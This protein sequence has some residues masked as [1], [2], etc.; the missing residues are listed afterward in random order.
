[1]KKILS[2]KFLFWHVL[3]CL[4]LIGSLS[5][6]ESIFKNYSIAEGL[7]HK[8]V[9][10]MLH[11][12]EG[13]VWVG[14]TSG[15]SRFDSYDFRNFTHFS[16]NTHALKGTTIGIILEGKDNRIWFLTD[17]GLEYFDKESETFHLVEAHG[18]KGNVYKK[19]TIDSEGNIWMLHAGYQF[20]AYN[21]YADSVFKIIDMPFVEKED[22]FNFLVD[23]NTL[24]FASKKGI[25]SYNL[26]NQE[27]RWLERSDHLH[28]STVKKINESTVVFTFFFEGICVLNT[29]S[30]SITWIRKEFIE[31]EIGTQITLYD[32]EVENDSVFWISVA[33]GL[34]RVVNGSVEYFN[35]FSNT[36]YFEG[37][38]VSCLYRDK[39]DNI[40]V[41]TYENGI[42]LKQKKN[43]DYV[44]STRLHRD[45]VRKTHMSNFHVFENNSLLYGDSKGIYYCDDY[46]NLSAG[47]AKRILDASIPRLFPFDER[48]CMMSSVDTFYVFDSWTKTVKYSHTTVAPACVYKDK[49]NDII[50]VGTWVGLLCGYDSDRNLKFQL[51]VDTLSKTQFPIFAIA[52]DADGS[53]WL[54]TV[55]VG[56]VHIINP[57]G[58]NPTIKFYNQNGTGDNFLNTNMIHS[59]HFDKDFNLWVG[60]NGN[61]VVRRDGKTKKMT[62]YTTEDGLKSNVIESIVSDNDGNIWFA[63]KVVTRLDVTSGTFTHFLQAEGIEGS[64][65][66]NACAKSASGDLLFA[67]SSGIYIFDPDNLKEDYPALPPILTQL[68]IR[69]VPVSAGDTIEGVVPYKKSITFTDK[70]SLP[71]A[72]NTFSIAFASIR[73]QESQM[74]D[75]QFKLDGVDRDW[76]PSGS[77]DR[78]ASYIGIQPGT[79]MFH[80]RA[81]YDSGKWSDAKTIKIN[82]IPPWWKTIWFNILLVLFSVLIITGFVVYRFQAIKRLNLLLERKVRQRTD[83]LIEANSLLQESY[84]VLEVKNEALDEALKTK[85]KLI[86]IIAHDFKNPLAAII[87]MITLLKD[88]YQQLNID[89]IQSILVSLTNSSAN[90]QE[91]MNSVLDWA[92]SEKQDVV[93][94][95]I[96]I[97]I[98]TLIN[99]SIKLVEDI[100]SQKKISI[101]CQ[102][103]YITTAYV[104]PRMISAVIRNLLINAIKF[105]PENGNIA[106][107]VQEYENEI[108]VSVVDSGIG[109]SADAIQLIFN[110]QESVS[111]HDTD[112]NTSTGLG[113]QLS[114]M[115]VEKNGGVLSARSQQNRGSVFIFTVPK[116]GSV[117]VK[118]QAKK[119]E[120][121]D[122][123]RL[124]D[125]ANVTVDK[126]A[127]I[128][129][130]DD[131]PNIISLLQN[132]FDSYYSV[133]VAVDGQSGVQ[134]ASNVVPSLIISDVS[135]PKLSGIDL[136]QI[137]KEDE[138]TNHIPIILITAD[139]KYMKEGY[140]SG[141]DDFIVKPFDEKE[142]LLKVHSLLENRKRI[143]ENTGFNRKGFLLPESHDDRVV[144]KLLAYVNENFCDPNLDTSKIGETVGLSRTQLWRK[145]K[146][147]TQKNLSDYIKDLRLSKAK[148]MLET[149][150]YKVSEVAYETGYTNPQYF[151][152]CFVKEFGFTPK[153]CIDKS[154]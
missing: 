19:T 100:A 88:K 7:V 63:S 133:F 115:F 50:W 92:L 25:G 101:S 144:S 151:T 71:Y 129:I 12:R 54:G 76:I 91:Q 119:N 99:D 70:I 103:D 39:N 29:S 121:L 79:Y 27:F 24:L 1:M 3:F 16:R 98:E 126:D 56:L 11:D 105:T 2:F 143:I 80:V 15:L 152:R 148:E 40:W 46:T 10:S 73:Y 41:G 69:G 35:Y 53:L 117:A 145:F 26:H 102:F 51:F 82:I 111:T 130:I 86:R 108:E 13:F 147:S 60:T 110:T 78:L 43:N 134:L 116:G 85:D 142:L 146:S 30:H 154:K 6:S 57:T 104:D 138:M 58:Q 150:K 28:C 96:E 68:R 17:V 106:I 14:T 95:P 32:T 120:L 66:A 153:E 149:G 128:L 141:A 125:I 23:G 122:E 47:C 65:I 107:V 72:L 123:S 114:K 33:P 89:K 84:A 87:G 81:S 49:K 127:V 93:F 113:L 124:I 139:E 5:A 118:V 97:N 83:K 21:P 9:T 55:G 52:G 67:S 136:C 94:K 132:V 42:F 38:V 45:D 112:N 8:S 4:C 34:V 90:L 62:V 20:I 22:I 61:G 77:G 37:N 131:N 74:I 18:I 59:L 140:A 135:M 75:Y 137:L 31:K 48:F 109:M 64:F 36:H 44:F